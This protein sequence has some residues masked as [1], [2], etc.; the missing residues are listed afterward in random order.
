MA[1]ETF[2]DRIIPTLELK[3]PFLKSWEAGKC[4]AHGTMEVHH[5]LPRHSNERLLDV[6]MAVSAMFSDCSEQNLVFSLI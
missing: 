3:M 5:D 1:L 2:S 4:Q 6:N